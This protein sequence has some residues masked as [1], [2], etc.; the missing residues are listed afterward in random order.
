MEKTKAGL[1][2]IAA[3][4]GKSAK[5]VF[6][7]A[8]ST[9][10]KAVDQNDDGQF[11]KED[12]SILAESI[13]TAAKNTALTMAERAQ[14]RSKEAALRLLQPIFPA[15]LA[16]PDFVLSKLIRITEP[17]KK[18]AE[19]EVCIGSV[20]FVSDQKD[21]KVINIYRDY[22]DLFALTFYPDMDSEVYYV[23]PCNPRHYIAL[24]DYF[25][26]LKV[27]RVN[28]LQKIAQDLGAK[29]FRVT[30]KEQKTTFSKC[31]AKA[32]G[33]IKVPAGTATLDG[34]HNLDARDLTSVEVAAEMECPGH[35]PQ[36]PR[37]HYLQ[38]EPSIQTLV[39]LRMDETS[40]I[41]HQKYT[42]KLSNSSGIKEKDA[43]KIDMA[44]KGMKIKGNTTMSS[45]FLNESRRYLEYEI[46]F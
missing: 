13:S 45:E 40:P 8:K 33:S 26:H 39:A 9:V 44:L 3:G 46:D 28:E 7:K 16:Q 20:G 21:M 23:D 11:G 29:H 4:V 42:L 19:S 38:K 17:D 2:S 37:L 32:D 12:V 24:E 41:S 34:A 43:A 30:Y 15:D 1:G 14:E 22:V 5:D 27:A 18:H 10:V 25:S 31:S 35:S 6:Q 36:L